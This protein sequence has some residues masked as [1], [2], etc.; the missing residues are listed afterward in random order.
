VSKLNAGSLRRAQNREEHRTA[1]FLHANMLTEPTTCV[2]LGEARVDAHRVGTLTL[3]WR[4]NYIST[5]EFE[6][7]TF[8]DSRGT[9]GRQLSLGLFGKRRSPLS[10]TKEFGDCREHSREAATCSILLAVPSGT[11]DAVSRLRVHQKP[12]RPSND[13][14]PRR[15]RLG[16]ATARR[17]RACCPVSS[18]RWVR[19]SARHS[20]KSPAG[21]RG[22]LLGR[23]VDRGGRN[24]NLPRSVP[25][26]HTAAGSG[27]FKHPRRSTP[28][29]GHQEKP[30]GAAPILR[31]KQNRGQG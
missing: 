18:V 1:G 12:S 10:C 7:N 24:G 23:S 16:P 19:R 2:P 5:A 3:L 25:V 27:P 20:E 9:F 28:P 14:Q 8:S 30:R 6:R 4:R 29:V 17:W 13:E 21:V 15:P 31:G 11:F 22:E 26:V